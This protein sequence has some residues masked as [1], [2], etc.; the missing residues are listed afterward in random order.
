MAKK[1]LYGFILVSVVF[2]LIQAWSTLLFGYQHQ[3]QQQ[4]SNEDNVH[5]QKDL[6]L[7]ESIKDLAQSCRESLQV[8]CILVDEE[9]LISYV[10]HQTALGGGDHKSEAFVGNFGASCGVFCG[11]DAASFFVDGDL[12]TLSM[13][14][15]F[16]ESLI[17]KGFMVYK[18]ERDDNRELSVEKRTSK[19]QLVYNLFMTR[20]ENFL[21]VSFGYSRY[22]RWWSNGCN[23]APIPHTALVDK[24]RVYLNKS[25]FCTHQRLINNYKNE[26]VIVDGAKVSVP[27]DI[28]DFIE[29]IRSSKYT[30]CVLKN[31]RKFYSEYGLRSDA[32][33]M[34]FRAKAKQLLLLAIRV[35]GDLSVPFWLS[36]GTC[37]GWYRQCGFIPHSKDVDIG[38]W[39]KH[40]KPQIVQGFL[41]RGLQLKHQF[42]KIEDSFE[43]SFT[44]G[45]L[46]LDIFF[47]YED[48]TSMWNGGTQARTGKKFKYIFPKFS[49]CWTHMSGLTVRVPCPA[50]PYVQANYGDNWNVLVKHWDWKAS[51]PNVRENGEWPVHERKRVIQV[52]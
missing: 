52:F 10:L 2:F 6:K 42:G 7:G 48:E 4:Q 44:L 12:I 36:S 18:D 30:P 47:F 43:L 50:L 16:K 15:L 19:H 17:R 24:W 51:P 39:I 8:E 45:D 23:H 40:Y 14:H 28:P 35:L 41:D 27:L 33:S 3:E 34:A 26:V 49:L 9:L 21:L 32:E 38:I 13:I 29:N 37:L 20:R 11:R 1:L 22:G 31:A 46:K 25:E 5:H